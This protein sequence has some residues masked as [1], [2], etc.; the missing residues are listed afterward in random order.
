MTLSRTTV[1]TPISPVLDPSDFCRACRGK[2]TVSYP[3][4]RGTI[5]TEPCYSCGG[6]GHKTN[7]FSEP[8]ES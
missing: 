2:K 3:S 7:I 8:E 1:A 5:L 4:G 6:T